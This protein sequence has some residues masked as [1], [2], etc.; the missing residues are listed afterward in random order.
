MIALSDY[1]GL[2]DKLDEEGIFDTILDIDAN[3]FINI[4]RI[5]DTKEKNFQNS[6]GRIQ[7][8]FLNIYKLLSSTTDKNSRL[9][10]QAVRIFDFPEISNIGLGYSKGRYGSGF[11][12][13]LAKK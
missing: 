2:G 7:Q 10:R 3:Y 5:K 6:Y 12:P 11:G 1:L 9:Y 4:K 13:V 8:F